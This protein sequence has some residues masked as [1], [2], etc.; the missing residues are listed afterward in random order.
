MIVVE[1]H[2][3]QVDVRLNKGYTFREQ[4]GY[5]FT[6]GMDGK[7]NPYPAEIIINLEEKQ[8]AWPVGKYQVSPSCVY[9]DRHKQLT[10]GRIKLVPV[11]PQAVRAAG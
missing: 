5:A 1:I 9:V 10:I 6:Y 7:P 4:H 2:S 8:D 3:T 11:P